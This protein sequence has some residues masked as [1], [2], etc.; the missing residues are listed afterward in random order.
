MNFMFSWHEQYITR[1]LRS[2]VRYCS[3]HSNIKFISSRYRVISSMYTLVYPCIPLYTLVYPC[4]LLYTHVYP[5]IPMYTLVYPCIPMYTLVYPC[6][7]LNTNVYP[8]TPMYTHV[9]PCI[10][11]YTLVYPCIPMYTL[12]Y[13]CIPLYTPVYPCI[14]LF[15]HVYPCIPLNTKYRRHSDPEG[16]Y[17]QNEIKWSNGL[18]DF[19]PNK[20]TLK[21]PCI[22]W[23]TPV[24]PCIFLYILVSL[25]LPPFQ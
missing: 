4:I 10:L 3:C 7:P 1:S 17:Y 16:R 14:P 23:Y 18:N 8:C 5:C 12:V 6:I 19:K 15:T 21:F 11:V 13:P 20:N 24:Y 22:P 2:L 9:Y 25:Y